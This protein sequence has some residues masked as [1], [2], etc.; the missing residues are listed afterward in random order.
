MRGQPVLKTVPKV[1]TADKNGF[2]P[3]VIAVLKTFQGLDANFYLWA[4]ECR[5][6]HQRLEEKKL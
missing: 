4:H 6:D 3:K 2:Q 1:Q 5:K